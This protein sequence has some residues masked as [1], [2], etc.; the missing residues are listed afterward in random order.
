MTPE[1]N[2][3]ATGVTAITLVT[4]ALAAAIVSLRGAAG[5]RMRP[6]EQAAEEP[7]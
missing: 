4:F 6:V 7:E 5:V 2:A 1:V 3:I